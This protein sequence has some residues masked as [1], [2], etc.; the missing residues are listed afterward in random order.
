MSTEPDTMASAATVIR[1]ADLT[2][3]I[4]CYLARVE[5]E[6][7]FGHYLIAQEALSQAADAMTELETFLGKMEAQRG[8]PLVGAT[9]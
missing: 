9:T 3:L 2:A 4:R 8:L 1:Y 5:M 7:A 6:A